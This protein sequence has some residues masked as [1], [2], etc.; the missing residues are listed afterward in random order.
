MLLISLSTPT[1]AQ[2]MID[3]LH[4]NHQ[5]RVHIINI[6]LQCSS[7][8]RD[9]PHHKDVALQNKSRCK[10]PIGHKTKQYPLRTSTIDESSVTGNIAVINDMYMNQLK[11][12]PEQLSDRAIPSI[13]DQSTDARIRGAKVLRSK[14]VDSF[15]R[16]DCFQLGFGLFHLSMNLIW[17]LLHVHW[18][19]AEH[20][21]SLSYFFVV[22]N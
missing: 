16:L 15:A 8:F 17:A 4:F 1:S 22:L 13:N 21:G 3:C 2:F 5:L 6:L 9:Y 20:P 18:G 14:D 12:M 11:I 7:Q 19:S 10:L